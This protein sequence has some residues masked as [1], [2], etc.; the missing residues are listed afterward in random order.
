[1]NVTRA[2]YDARRD[3]L[4]AGHA[5][6]DREWVERFVYYCTVADGDWYTLF[7]RIANRHYHVPN[8]PAP[9]CGR[10]PST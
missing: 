1:M 10:R 6:A 7:D 8:T 5:L 3:S 4:A 2:F 9:R